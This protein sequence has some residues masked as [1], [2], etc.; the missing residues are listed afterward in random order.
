M[1]AVAD[2]R[3]EQKAVATP[4]NRQHSVRRE[5]RTPAQSHLWTLPPWQVRGRFETVR[6]LPGKRC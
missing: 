4:A 1:R 6:L 3:S 2:E 5:S